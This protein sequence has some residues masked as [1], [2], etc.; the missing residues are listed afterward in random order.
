MY[1]MSGFHCK[2]RV[3]WEVL[4]SLFI[5]CCPHYDSAEGER[6][7]EGLPPGPGSMAVC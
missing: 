6:E 3:P 1:E 2:R 5:S 4:L 7:K